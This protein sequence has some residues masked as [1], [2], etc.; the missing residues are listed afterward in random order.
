MV[1]ARDTGAA[2]PLTLDQAIALGLKGNTEIVLRGQQERFVKGE[3]LSVA[4]ALFPNLTATAYTQAQEVNLA[5]MGFKPGS[6]RIPGFTGTIPN[7]V[8]VNTTSAQLQVSQTLA[9]PA[10]YLY[11][12]ARKAGEA[13]GWATLSAR[14]G[15]VLGV[16]GLYLRTLADEAQLRD[17]RARVRQDAAV[18]GQAKARRD[19]GVGINLDVLR[20]QVQ[21]QAEQQAVIRDEATVR[22]DKIALNREM[23]QPAG[24]ELDLVDAVPFGEFAAM[25][26]EE[27]KALAYTRRKDLLGLQAQLA[28]AEG[29]EKAVKYE[30]LPTVGFGGFYGVVGET[31]GLYHGVFAAQ[32]RVNVP[33]FQRGTLHGQMEVASAQ[34]RA[35]RNQIASLKVGIEADLRASTLDVETARKLVD[36]ARSNEALAAEEVGDATLRFGAGVD[37]SLP[38][39]RAQTTLAGAE[40]QVVQAEFGYNY[41]KLV[42]ARNTGVVETQYRDFLR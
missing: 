19:A 23:G 28:A 8:K 4:N 35:L 2:M 22:K 41:A 37:D 26:L 25:P 3:I 9:L 16:G 14:G 15:V 7:I 18:F 6:V 29:A 32:G 12:A 20:A 31:T 1:V 10:L 21:L 38:L 39:V 17:V 13:A 27:A 11:R 33:I 5:A 36:V 24:Q 42:L 30:R 40:A 34:V